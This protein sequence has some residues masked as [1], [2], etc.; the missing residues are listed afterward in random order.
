MGIT[1]ESFEP[2]PTTPPSASSAHYYVLLPLVDK[3]KPCC[4]A[5]CL[6]LSFVSSFV[7]VGIASSNIILV[8]FPFIVI[9]VCGIYFYFFQNFQIIETDDD[10]R[11]DDDYVEEQKVIVEAF[12][13]LWSFKTD[14]Q[15]QLQ[16]D[17]NFLTQ[18][19]V[20]KDYSDGS[21]NGIGSFCINT[22]SDAE[23]TK[24]PNRSLYTRVHGDDDDDNGGNVGGCLGGETDVEWQPGEEDWKTLVAGTRKRR[25]RSQFGSFRELCDCYRAWYYHE[26]IGDPAEPKTAMFLYSAFRFGYC[27]ESQMIPG[28]HLRMF[29]ARLEEYITKL[30]YVERHRFRTMLVFLVYLGLPLYLLL[31]SILHDALLLF[32]FAGFLILFC[33][34]YFGLCYPCKRDVDDDDKFAQYAS[35]M[36]IGKQWRKLAIRHDL[37]TYVH[38]VQNSRAL[39]IDEYL[40]RVPY[41][42]VS[43]KDPSEQHCIFVSH[44]WQTQEHPDPTGSST[45]RICEYGQ[46]VQDILSFLIMSST[47][48][49]EYHRFD[50]VAETI[51]KQIQNPFDEFYAAISFLI[52]KQKE[53]LLWYDFQ[54]VPQGKDSASKGIR[55][56]CLNEIEHICNKMPLYIDAIHGE[57]YGSAE[58]SRYMNRGWCFFELFQGIVSGVGDFEEYRFFPLRHR[59]DVSRIYVQICD[60]LPTGWEAKQEGTVA[61]IAK[62]FTNL[63]IQCTNGDDTVFLAARLKK[64][65]SLQSCQRRNKEPIEM[66]IHPM[67]TARVLFWDKIDYN[68]YTHAKWSLFFDRIMEEICWHYITKYS[69]PFDGSSNFNFVSFLPTV[70]TTKET[71]ERYDAKIIA[72]DRALRLSTHYPAK[73]L[74]Y[75]VHTKH[76]YF[77]IHGYNH[78]VAK[79]LELLFTM[80]CHLCTFFD[81]F[82]LTEGNIIG[83]FRDMLNNRTNEERLFY[84]LNQGQAVALSKAWRCCEILD[85]YLLQMP[86]AYRVHLVF[87]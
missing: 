86:N 82:D 70:M 61:S 10:D 64:A 15:V 80:A 76:P 51:R 72:T 73:I 75:L 41:E 62:A 81:L 56:K 6:M 40:S 28:I 19:F 47:S 7:T 79:L 24:N 22:T 63:D 50:R 29:V 33:W 77:L 32:F 57:D 45:A 55:R 30:E 87:E 21:A 5:L 37:Q 58:L 46:K 13:D 78:D 20:M 48:S 43:V 23:T 44:R 65:F 38:P 36:Y 53:V 17:R 26:P 14:G 34:K 35:W 39:T 11:G 16:R 8:V 59:L 2:P 18:I 84:R 9:I 74:E 31:F 66:V 25:I 60:T 67:A 49:E 27:L 42:K 3:H 83:L 71:T 69:I 4:S 12:C 1:P 54:S 68:G 52:H 85:T